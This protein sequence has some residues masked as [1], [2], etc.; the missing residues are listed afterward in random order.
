[1]T[2]AEWMIFAAVIL[3]L[4]TVAPV[5]A[6]GHKSFDNSNPR[7]PEFYKPGIAARALGAHINGIETFPFFAAAVL[8]AEFRHG[9]QVWIDALAVAFVMVRLLFVGA[10]IGNWPTTR[11]LLWNLGFAVN[12]AIFFMPWWAGVHA[13]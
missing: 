7:A 5:K 10:Y 11:T 8:L 3:Y 6:I 2:V 4:L 12:T 13:R 1:M 9:P